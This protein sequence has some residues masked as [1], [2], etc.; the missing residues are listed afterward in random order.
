MSFPAYPVYKDSGVEWQ[1]AVPA[2]WP[3]SALKYLADYQNGY[4]FK[5]DDWGVEGLPII[6]IAQLTGDS[7]PNY[8]AGE[9]DDCVRVNDGDL[10]FSWSATIDSFIW[11]GGDAWLN[12]HIFKVTC[13]DEADQQFLFYLIKLVAPKLADFDAHGSTMKHIKK[14][15]LSERLHVPTLLEQVQIARFLDHETARIDALIEEQQRLIQLLKEKRQAAISLAVTKGLNPTVQMKDSGVQWL[16]EVPAHWR[17]RKVKRLFTQSKQ[18]GYT[19]MEVLS[20]YRDYGVIKKSSRN[21]NNNKTPDDLSLYQLVMAGDLV[22]NKMKA[23]QGSLG[24]SDHQGITSPDYVVYR[25]SHGESSK[26]LHYLFRASHM[27]KVY[28]SISNGIRPSQWRIEPEKFEQ[29]EVFLPAKAEQLEIVRY[30]ENQLTRIDEL[31]LCCEQASKFLSERRSTLISAAVTGK[32]DVRGWQ[33]QVN[34]PSPELAE[35][36]V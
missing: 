22:V 31:I 32:I 29:I 36:A 10:L 9:L 13:S 20:V 30:L 34:T 6:R 7:A 27:P 14:E 15:S 17:S 3:R 21:D 5:P 2:D 35:E 23:W 1:G 28:L 4:P 33:P 18:Q 11:S 19:D 24:V 25:P 8:Y 26:F 12:Q 16:G